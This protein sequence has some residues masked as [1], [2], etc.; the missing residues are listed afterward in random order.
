MENIGTAT[1]SPDDNKLRIYPFSRLDPEIYERVKAAGYKWAPNQKLFVAPM[2]TPA[3]ADLAVELC[4]DIEDEDKTLTERADERAERFEDYSEKRANDANQARN[5]VSAIADNIPFG[6][7]ILIGHHSEK[8]AR[9]HAEKIENGMRKAVKMW[10]TSAYWTQRAAGALAHAKYKEL[11]GVRARRIKGIEA[12]KRKQERNRVDAAKSLALWTVD[13]LTIEQ[14]RHIANYGRGGPIVSKVNADG[15]PY[16]TTYSGWNAYDVLQPDGERYKAC[17]SCT[18][19]QCQ[20]AARKL[21]PRVI[22]HCDRWIEHYSNRLAYEHAMLDEQGAT[23]LLAPKPRTNAATLPLCNYSVATGLDIPNM[24]HRGEMVH[25]PMHH[26]TKAEFA[27]INKDCKGTRVIGNSHRVRTA[28]IRDSEARRNDPNGLGA[29]GM[30]LCVIFLTDSK[31]H[32]PPFSIDPEP[33]KHDGAAA[34]RSAEAY[35][36][37]EIARQEEKEKSAD[38]QAMKDSLKAGVKIVTAPQLFPTPRDLAERM[39]DLLDVQHGQRVLEPSA[40]TGMLLGAIGC[41][42]IGLDQEHAGLTHAIEINRILAGRLQADFPL[43]RVYCED[44]LS[45]NPGEFDRIIMN[46]PFANA[47][48][49]KHIKHAA[50]MLKQGG[51][52]VALCANGPR[53][54]EALQPLASYWE[55]LPANTFAVSGTGV[56]V[57]LLIIEGCESLYPSGW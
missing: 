44:F 12:D 46:P 20:E 36:E 16:H 21:Y 13:G 27:A 53:Q 49:I 14:A 28:M 43:T 30:K 18:V 45:F 23:D 9:K 24:Y 55:D 29:H 42:N 17:P 34:I 6:Q 57:A 40:G 25:Y 47:D 5:A 31:T 7:P 19:E 41:R 2:W 54:R 38:F 35:R 10:E 48:D 26:M 11:P 4:D 1:Y 51:R 56:N 22:A 50:S 39:A 15:T 8:H 32:E 33:P 52:L 37:R 3:R